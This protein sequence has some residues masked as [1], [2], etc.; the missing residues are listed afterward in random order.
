LARKSAHSKAAPD[1]DSLADELADKLAMDAVDRAYLA[2]F[3]LGNAALE[4]EVLELF[5]AQA[6]VYLQRL[7]EAVCIKAWREATHTIKGSASAIGAWRLARLA[8]MAENFDVEADT[9]LREAHRDEAV[10]AVAM[11]TEEA[12]RFIARLYPAA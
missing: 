10:A 6:P 4:R 5:A 7:R 3:T 12:C 11:A 2:R 9:A 8:E 1:F